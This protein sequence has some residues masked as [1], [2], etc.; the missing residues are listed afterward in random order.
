MSSSEPSTALVLVPVD[1]AGQQWPLWQ[2]QGDEEKRVL[3]L[4]LAKWAEQKNPSAIV[5]MIG[6]HEA[7]LMD[8]GDLVRYEI[9]PPAG[10]GKARTATYLNEAQ[11]LYLLAKMETTKAKAMLKVV[12]EVFIAARR[13][14]LLA[15]AEDPKLARVRAEQRR[16]D[17][18]ER[19]LALQERRDQAGALDRLV[20]DFAARGRIKDD[21]RDAYKVVATEIRTG[22]SLKALKPSVEPAWLSPT[23]IAAQLGVSAQKVGTTIT[24]LGLRGK[25]GFSRAILT[26]SPHSVKTVESYLYSPEAVKL[27]SENIRG[28]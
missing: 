5:E 16:L 28:S 19:R 2:R 7:D 23:E 20:D 1:H 3:D 18:A 8:L 12:I 22:L 4:D 24:A 27:I 13:G 15:Q 25:E 26:K 10:G 14:E 9:A 17:L 6:R 21:V 11:S